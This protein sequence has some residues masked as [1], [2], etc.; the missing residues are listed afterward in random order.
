MIFP[1]LAITGVALSK[2]FLVPKGELSELIPFIDLSKLSR[3][4][5]NNSF[6]TLSVQQMR[7]SLPTFSWVLS[8]V[9]GGAYWLVPV[10]PRFQRMPVSSV[11]QKDFSSFIVCPS[12]SSLP[13]GCSRGQAQPFSFPFGWIR[14]YRSCIAWTIGLFCKLGSPVREHGLAGNPTHNEVEFQD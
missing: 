10:V 6:W 13:R 5:D 7:S 9:L 12:D 3:N 4:V 11:G 14:A 1:C 2:V 8:L